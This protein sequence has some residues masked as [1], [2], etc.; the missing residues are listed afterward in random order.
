M[1]C[2]RFA[3]IIIF[4]ALSNLA[5]GSSWA[6]ESNIT[7]RS[8]IEG[9]TTSRLENDL[10]LKRYEIAELG[11]LENQAQDASSK[12]KGELDSNL[13]ESDGSSDVEPPMAIDKSLSL[14]AVAITSAI[15]MLLLWLLFRKPVTNEET[16]VE[17]TADQEQETL[18][19][20]DDGSCLE[21]VVDEQIIPT[22]V[23]SAIKLVKQSEPLV[24]NKSNSEMNTVV[25]SLTTINPR[26]N[27]NSN[28]DYI[29]V[30]FELI[31]DL[32]QRD[33]RIRRKAIWELA[34]IG[35]HRSVEPLVAILPKA[36][37][38]DRSL[39]IKAITHI[40]NRNFKPVNKHLL[41]LLNDENPQVR[42]NAIL[43]LTAFYKFVIPMTHQ[44]NRMQLDRD[45]EVRQTAR[46]AIQNLNLNYSVAKFNSKAS[47]VPLED[48]SKANRI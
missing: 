7:E 40:T 44:L 20:V 21:S 28:N 46:E 26:I 30:V 10:N 22:P 31:Q 23:Y 18:K 25:D 38:V 8:L 2:E 6:T 14:A 9:T 34:K 19:K 11:N 16:A 4:S 45:Q 35:D 43:D 37:S 33:R 32:Q 29:D 17:L 15:S 24:V 5:V 39:I 3:F 41:A 27:I 42:T 12:F 48:K 1:I 13:E 36:G 47:S